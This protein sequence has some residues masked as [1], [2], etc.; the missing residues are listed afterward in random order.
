MQTSMHP[1]VDVMSEVKTVFVEGLT[2]EWNEEHV[3]EICKQYGEIVK[4]SQSL[5]TKCEDF[6]FITFTSR[7]S[8][9]ALWRGSIMLL[10]EV[11]ASIAKPQ[12]KGQ[13]QKQGFHGGFKVKKERKVVSSKKENE[14]TRQTG[15]SNRKGNA[16]SKWAK[17]KGKAVAEEKGKTLSE[18]KN[19]RG[20]RPSKKSQG[21]SRRRQINNFRNLKR[22]PHI[23]KGP[24]YGADSAVY[25]NPY[26]PGYA[27]PSSSYHGHSH[28][29]ISGAKRHHTDMELHAGYLEPVSRK[30][31][32]LYS[33]YLE[34][35]VSIE[36]QPHAGYLEPAVGT[37]GPPHAIYLE[38]SVGTQGQ[39]PSGFLV[40]ELMD[41]LNMLL[42]NLVTIHMAPGSALPPSYVPNYTSYAGYQGGSSISG[43]YQSSGGYLPPKAY[44]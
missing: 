20:K 31:G 41:T 7:E 32:Q 10:L 29:A 19:V 33:E 1:N 8:A 4:F 25:R 39:P 3:K 27:A 38:P 22:D 18:S 16:K 6:G 36:G 12:F 17:R 9:L 42:E 34:P 40:L 37:H 5:G 15:S 30:Q 43:Y 23:R 11:K 44:Y 24:D 35:A 21:K 13:L 14:S 28:S 26:A 2:D